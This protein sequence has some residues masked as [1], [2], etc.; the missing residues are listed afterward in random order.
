MEKNR[1]SINAKMTLIATIG[2]VVSMSFIFSVVYINL[3]DLSDNTLN[4]I[5]EELYTLTD[6][7]YEHYIEAVNSNIEVYIDNIFGELHIL[8]GITQTY[9]N[10]SDELSDF[11]TFVSNHDYFKDQLEFSGN[12][13]QNSSIEPTS[14]FIPRYLLNDDYTIKDEMKNIVDKTA[15]LD[16]VM[17][18][19][20]QNGTDKI[21]L[22]YQGGQMKEIVRMAPWTNIGEEV[23]DVYPDLNDTPLWDTFNPGLSEEWRNMIQQS[24][25]NM[26]LM[27]S[28]QLVTPPVQDGITGEIILTFFQPLTNNL[29]NDFE[30]TISFDV[31]IDEIIKVVEEVKFS[32]TGFAFLTQSNSNIFAINEKGGQILGLGN[33]EENITQTE[34]GFNHL[35]RYFNNSKYESVRNIEM[36]FSKEPIFDELKIGNQEFVLITKSFDIYQSWT[37]EK[38][39]FDEIWTLGFVVP[40][41]EIFK[42]YYNT[43]GEIHRNRQ[44]T[45]LNIG[46]M[47]VIVLLSLIG[48]IILS[49]RRVTRDLNTL[50]YAANAIKNNNYD[51]EINVRSNDEIGELSE[52]FK[53]MLKEIKSNFKTMELQNSGLMKEIEERK[54]KEKI[55][56]HL[57][58]FDTLTDLPNMKVLT[59]ILRDTALKNDDSIISIIVIGL[60]DFRKI[61]EAYGFSV[62]DI[63]IKSIGERLKSVA[64]SYKFPFKL[65]GDEF[66]FIFE[67]ECIDGLLIK[68]EEIRDHVSSLYLIEGNEILITSSIG[69]SSLPLDS[70]DPLE[71]LEKANVAMVHA[72]ENKKGNY[73]FYNLDMNNMAR[74]RLE[75]ISELR[76]SLDKNEM[77]MVFQPIVDIVNGQFNG[78]EALVRWES[79]KF[80][81]I[82]PMIFIPLAEETKLIIKIGQWIIRESL[83]RMKAIHNLGFKDM[84]ISI[85]LSVVEIIESDL[86]S[87]IKSVI[88]EIGIDPSKVIMEITEGLF[89]EDL[90][91]VSEV[92]VGLRAL[93][94]SISVDDFGTGYSSLNY[95]QNLPLSKLKIDKS[96]V[97]KIN[98][99]TSG[100]IINAI[101]ALSK[102]LNLSVIAE[103]IETIE[104]C[105]Y[106]LSNGCEEG[107]G[108]YY[109]K[110]LEYEI[111]LRT[112]EDNMNSVSKK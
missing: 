89:I 8:S 80:G 106:L 44:S 98:E 34:S 33:V 93:G 1:L 84:Y 65:S 91:K 16:L 100:G 51:V 21:Q 49:N 72:K 35:E 95:L 78:V 73:Q 101:I 3:R 97:S 83:S 61:N 32:E 31:S 25:G 111:L 39:F 66:C 40:K 57:E 90:N 5:E 43:K 64:N 70:L 69:I 47:G 71:V 94:V 56:N 88:E 63:L 9:F 15:F 52:V 28:L 26:N 74:K 67:T 79:E 17:P 81:S 109:A 48:Y 105:E 76:K 29:M 37:P 11:T 30:G 55:I 19:F 4:I 82:S 53:N 54:E 6:E 110:P 104:Q 27:K 68:L 20:Y 22:Y 36:K 7:Y 108:Y 14:I 85:N 58:S 60:D 45:L 10:D 46:I 12:W 107:Q 96:F 112:L 50:T 103:G 77:K 23:Y 99:E 92:L 18:S 13:Y 75:M 62:G 2:I 24:E 87:Y 38:G 41:E 42:M 59:N 86:V 102:S